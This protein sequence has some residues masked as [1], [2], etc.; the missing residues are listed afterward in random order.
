MSGY[1]NGVLGKL[2]RAAAVRERGGLMVCCDMEREGERDHGF[3]N[4]GKERG[5]PRQ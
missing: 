2:V 1:V 4:R 5:V 3:Q